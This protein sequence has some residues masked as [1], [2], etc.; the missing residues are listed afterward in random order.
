MSIR[1]YIDLIEA[2][3]NSDSASLF[4]TRLAALDLPASINA[5]VIDPDTVELTDL[6]A[7]ECG[8]GHGRAT[9]Q[10]VL[11]LAD[12]LSITLE[13]W[14]VYDDAVEDGLTPGDLEY[15]RYLVR[16]PRKG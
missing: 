4:V 11:S 13:L 9:M 2:A 6:E 10:A 1:N 15:D 5:Y 7:T 8:K 14:S 12:E 3:Q 16:Q